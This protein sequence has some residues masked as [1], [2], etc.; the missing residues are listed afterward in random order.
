[1]FHMICYK[2]QL[3]IEETYMNE[4][5]C[6]KRCYNKRKKSK[7]VVVEDGKCVLWHNDGPDPSV[8]SQAVLIDWLMIEGN[9]LKWK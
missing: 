5:V 7:A 6:G 3:F 1:M 2:N 9:Y 4:G 8:N